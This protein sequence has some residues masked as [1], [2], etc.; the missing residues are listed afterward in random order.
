[1]S[2]IYS[3]YCSVGSFVVT[4]LS[5]GIGE[6]PI[7]LS[8]IHCHGSEERLVNCSRNLENLANC[9]HSQDVGVRCQGI[10]PSLLCMCNL[11]HV[12]Y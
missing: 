3:I 8:G 9:T 5:F 12:Q 2:E 10:V 4:D 1:M 6:G 7:Y 11:E